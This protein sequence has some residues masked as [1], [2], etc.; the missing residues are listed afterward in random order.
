MDRHAIA[1]IL[2]EIG[3]LLELKGESPFKSN[4][5]YNAARTIESITEDL[6]GL[7][8]SG[9]IRELK[10]I[11]QALAEKL[12]EL[13]GTGRLEYY[14]ELKRSVPPGLLEMT[15]IPGLGPK[16]ITAV[17]NQL[18]ITTVGE[19]EYA[20]VENRLV[21]LPGFGQ[22]TQN[23][24]QQ[25]ILQMKRRRGFHLFAN[26]VGEAE[27]ILGVIRQSAGVRRAELVGD[28]RRCLE[29][30]NAISVLAAADRP[31]AVLIGLQQIEDLTELT[32]SG[33]EVT[34]KSSLGVP[35]RV[36]VSGD[37]TPHA[38]L[39]QTGSDEHL[40]ALATRAARMNVP[41]NLEDNG[42]GATRPQADS[43]EALY[44]ALGLPFIAPELREGLG[45]IE[46]AE[47]GHLNP[48]VEAGQIRGIFHNHTTYSDG[49]ASLDDMVAAAKALGYEYIG[50]SDHSQSA[51]Y[52][53]GLKEDRIREQHA[54]IDALR[55]RVTG[56][57]VFK[58]IEADILADGSMDYP[59]EV[60]ARFDFVIASVH[61]R[62]TLSEEE[63]TT[64]VVRALANPHVTMLGHP[65][66][67]L[68]LSREGYRIDLKRVIDAAK[69]Y[70][71]VVE[72]NANPHRL[73]LDW[74][75]C[76]SAKAQGV[77]VSINPDA[78]STE[79]LEDVPFGVNMAR[80]GG[81]EASDVINTLGPD[82]I[83]PALTARPRLQ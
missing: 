41:W 56:I 8:A 39:A 61:S 71:K 82:E 49:S 24:I 75:S 34:A 73:D 25:G 62:F 37:L 59:D 70:G 1:A 48:L 79:G 22:K 45:E 67:R 78:H 35:L 69:G 15:A 6:H 10:G 36:V 31:E 55:K 83:L 58:G 53:N 81:L 76:R 2:E 38:L 12:A 20:C 66:G 42:H 74:R 30:V 44:K 7:V 68:L 18:G 47:A 16:K 72:L 51:F 4:A 43:E 65:T 19:L 33:R 27:R 21:G 57:A 80:K 60:L 28:L 40:K 13:V 29:V 3:L 52:A 77:K 5:Y 64:R 54:Q 23:K 17:W 26:V 50:I 14:D 9:R 11:G 63:Q 46:A 32:V